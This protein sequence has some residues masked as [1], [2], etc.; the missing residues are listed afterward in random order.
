MSVK[1]GQ[2]TGECELKALTVSKI[3]KSLSVGNGEFTSIF[4]SW[5]IANSQSLDEGHVCDG[6]GDRTTS[7][8]DYIMALER[9]DS[10]GFNLSLIHI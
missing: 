2:V 6:V 8:D 10:Q 5:S 4:S 9:E 3:P 1:P 7:Y